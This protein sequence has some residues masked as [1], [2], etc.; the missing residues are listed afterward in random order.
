MWLFLLCCLNCWF[1]CIQ[2]WL[3]VQHHKLECLWK[4]LDYC[5]VKVTVKVQNVNEC[6][7]RWYPENQRTFCYQQ[8]ISFELQNILLPNFVL[9]C[10]I[11]SLSVM[12]KH[13]LAIFKVK[14][15]VRA[16]MI[17]KWLFLYYIFWT[18]DFLATKPGSMVQDC[19][20]ECLVKKIGLLHSRSRSLQRLKMSMNICPDIL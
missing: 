17:K 7:F 1:V 8:M 20:P 12:W 4:K 19:K 2:T 15:T 3:L 5:K 11:I 16:H 13:L 14:V 6:L 10:S 18:A 9:W